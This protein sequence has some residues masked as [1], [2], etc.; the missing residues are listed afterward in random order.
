M[1]VATVVSK[2]HWTRFSKPVNLG[3]N[4][5]D[6]GIERRVFGESGVKWSKD[7]IHLGNNHCVSINN[8]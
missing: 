7:I 5:I 4:L 1:V 3:P 2:P 6:T 8:M